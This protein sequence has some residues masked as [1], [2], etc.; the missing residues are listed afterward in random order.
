MQEL[1]IA[2]K[3]LL[4][5]QSKVLI[6]LELIKNKYLDTFVVGLVLNFCLDTAVHH[7]ILVQPVSRELTPNFGLNLQK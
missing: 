6:C 5:E 4:V 2:D 1:Q 3:S 7:E